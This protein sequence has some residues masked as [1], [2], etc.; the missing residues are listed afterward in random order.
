MFL[1]H[2]LYSYLKVLEGYH[3]N[4]MCTKIYETWFVWMI[5]LWFLAI[6]LIKVK[7]TSNFFDKSQVTSKLNFFDYYKEKENDFQK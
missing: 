7:M 2:K 6:D 1:I 3:S 4:E 5:L